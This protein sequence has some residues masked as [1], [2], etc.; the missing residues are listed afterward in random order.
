MPGSRNPTARRSCRAIA[1]SATTGIGDTRYSGFSIRLGSFWP[2]ARGIQRLQ[3]VDVLPEPGRAAR[4]RPRAADDGCGLAGIQRREQSQR[5]VRCLSAAAHRRG[6]AH[7]STSSA[8]HLAAHER[9][10]RS[11]GGSG[12]AR[13]RH[14]GE[15]ERFAA[16]ARRPQERRWQEHRSAR[17]YGRLSLPAPASRSTKSRSW[18]VT[19]VSIGRRRAYHVA[20]RLGGGNP[21]SSTLIR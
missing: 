17:G 13:H 21:R 15:L 14:R 7:R 2:S 16:A 1:P 5:A 10:G 20:L 8:T 6:A 12:A 11:D 19:K 18:R 9:P 3:G 4:S